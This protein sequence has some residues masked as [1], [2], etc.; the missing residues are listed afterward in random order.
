[1]KRI[2]FS[3]LACTLVSPLMA[4]PTATIYKVQLPN[5]DDQ[6]YRLAAPSSLPTPKLDPPAP[7]TGRK[8]SENTAIFLA[9]AWA[10]GMAD[11]KEPYN[12]SS[13]PGRG[14]MVS[15]G[16][17]EAGGFFHAS[18]VRA[19][20]AKYVNGRVPYYLVH[21]RGK[22]G[23]TTQSFYAAV[24]PDGRIIQPAPLRVVRYAENRRNETHPRGDQNVIESRRKMSFTVK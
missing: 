16:T 15:L 8:V 7:S 18:E 5:G 1:M 14:S 11:E 12:G 6:Y 21:L 24:L 3:M 20:S 2:L 23:D 13:N 10:G 17:A 19:D 22:I 4:A 9:I